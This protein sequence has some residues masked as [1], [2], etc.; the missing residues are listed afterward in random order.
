MNLKAGTTYR[1]T[2]FEWNDWNLS[3]FS[4]VGLDHES[5]GS[6]TLGFQ[7]IGWNSLDNGTQGWTTSSTQY[8]QRTTTHNCGMSGQTGASWWTRGGNV[9]TSLVPK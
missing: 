7:G 9:D 2:G 1:N 8:A 6:L 5:D 4:S 3:G